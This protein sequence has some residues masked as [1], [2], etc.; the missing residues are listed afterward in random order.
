MGHWFVLVAIDYVTKWIEV[1]A[2][3]NMTRKEVIEFVNE[4]I[5]YRFDISKTLSKD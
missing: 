4:H 1:V 5:R 3:K 2:L